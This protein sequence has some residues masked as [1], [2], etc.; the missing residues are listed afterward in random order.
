MDNDNTVS[1]NKY[2]STTGLCS[3]READRL[4]E[5]GRVSINRHPARKGNRVGPKD[6]VLVDGRPLDDRP[7]TIY[8]A[9]NKPVGIVCTTDDRAKDNIIRY[10]NYPERLFPIGR[11]DK[12]S[13][14]LIFL[15]NDGDIVNKILRAGNK[16]EKEYVVHVDKAITEK[17]LKNMS[18]G[19]QILDRVTKR[20]EVEQIT[21]LSF[22]I[23]LTQGMNRQ[24][25]RMCTHLGY[26]VVKLKRIRVMHVTLEHIPPGEWR[27]FTPEE[28]AKMEEV[29]AKSTNLS[30]KERSKPRPKKK[31]HTTTSRS[32]GGG[33]SKG[34][35]KG[36]GGQASSTKAK[37]KKKFGPRVG[38]SKKR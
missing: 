20:C 35:Y 16:H 27:E 17:F 25:R 5:R 4:I 23:I 30:A 29:L 14:G 15:T 10:L 31:P 28:M 8:L 11:L 7:E 19:V 21:P 6:K 32:S 2:I 3:R 22:R 12:P 18:S 9:F 34:K 36:R 26:E 1:L 33:P 24:I 38:K 13:E 37:P